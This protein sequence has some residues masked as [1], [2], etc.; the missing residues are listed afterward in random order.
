MIRKVGSRKSTT[1]NANVMEVV[2]LEE[3]RLKVLLERL[4]CDSEHD[5]KT[6]LEEM[7][8]TMNVGVMVA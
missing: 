4:R 8:A 3:Y 6:G 7:A 1:T 2:E 5:Q